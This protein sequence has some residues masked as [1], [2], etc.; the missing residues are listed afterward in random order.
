MNPESIMRKMAIKRPG[1]KPAANKPAIDTLI[2]DPYI[3]IILLGGIVGPMIEDAAVT[4]A[5]K[6]LSYPSSSMAGISMVPMAAVSDTAA[7]V[8]PEKKILAIATLLLRF[9]MKCN[10]FEALEK[11]IA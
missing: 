11:K 6:S 7:P 4:A 1:T 5:L 10:Q 3:T 9:I 8:I 2:S